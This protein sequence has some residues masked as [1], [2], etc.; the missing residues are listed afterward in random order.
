M[1]GFATWADREVDRRAGE[2]SIVKLGAEGD[3]QVGGS[4]DCGCVGEDCQI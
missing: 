1:S 3:A 4:G 2:A